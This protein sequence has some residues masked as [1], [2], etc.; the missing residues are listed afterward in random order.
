MQSMN[1]FDVV[2]DLVANRVTILRV[3]DRADRWYGAHQSEV[4]K[5]MDGLF[6]ECHGVLS[7]PLL[8]K[9]QQNLGTMVA[10]S[11]DGWTPVR[12]GLAPG[13]VIKPKPQA[14]AAFARD[15]LEQ[16][17]KGPQYP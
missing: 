10:E 7:R 16:L 4:A 14:I 5:L 13:V 2:Y 15:G 12:V 17:L 11:K 3:H 6:A 9:V 8:E 1:D